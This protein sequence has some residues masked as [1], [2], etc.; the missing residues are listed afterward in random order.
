MNMGLNR[1]GTKRNIFT[2][3]QH[4]SVLV[5]FDWDHS[6]FILPGSWKLLEV[7]LPQVKKDGKIRG[8]M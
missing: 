3:N 7:S 4:W 8:N 2:S 1:K 6:G 5:E